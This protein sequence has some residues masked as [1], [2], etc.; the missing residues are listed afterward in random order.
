MDALEETSTERPELPGS[1][2]CGNVQS[3]T[4]QE[5]RETINQ[6][7][8]LDVAEITPSILYEYSC[9]NDVVHTGPESRLNDRHISLLQ[10]VLQWPNT[11]KR[12]FKRITDRMRFVITCRAWKVLFH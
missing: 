7:L 8:D 3:N 2:P 10:E 1:N 6:T 9:T 12:M 11:S 4:D 5:Q